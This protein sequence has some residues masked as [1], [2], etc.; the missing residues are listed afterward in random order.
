M[1]NYL[2]D[3]NYINSNDLSDYTGN[4]VSQADFE[5]LSNSLSNVIR[6]SD[7]D[8]ELISTGSNSEDT[9]SNTTRI[10]VLEENV[11]SLS[12]NMI[13]GASFNSNMLMLERNNGSNVSVDLSSL[14]NSSSI[15]DSTVSDGGGV[16]PFA[17]SNLSLSLDPN[18]G[19][20]VKYGDSY[21]NCISMSNIQEYIYT[22]SE[23]RPPQSTTT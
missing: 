2:N 23:Y 8:D 7:L 3:N 20:C 4:F 10:N 17:E 22:K 15:G 12:N 6:T 18:N 21:S 16:T 9:A 11:E 5:S 13:N 14:N 1:S 19:L